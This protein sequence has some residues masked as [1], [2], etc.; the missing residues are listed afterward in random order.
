ML[1]NYWEGVMRNGDWNGSKAYC[2]PH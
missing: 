2:S 1:E